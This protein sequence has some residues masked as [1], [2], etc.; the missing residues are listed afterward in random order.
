MRELPPADPEGNL[1]LITVVEEGPHVIRLKVEIV[2]AILG[3]MRISLE[4]VTWIAF[5]HLLLSFPA[6][7]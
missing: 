7:N 4:F 1:D 2:P 5:L 6:K 3:G